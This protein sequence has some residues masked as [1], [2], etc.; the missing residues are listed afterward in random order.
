MKNLEWFQQ[1]AKK[2]HR[3]IRQLQHVVGVSNKSIEEDKTFNIDD[4]ED[5][6]VPGSSNGFDLVNFIA[7]RS[8]G[9][10]KAQ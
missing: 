3:C 10:P 5:L 8:N 6:L 7:S 2:E 4:D 1:L 9:S